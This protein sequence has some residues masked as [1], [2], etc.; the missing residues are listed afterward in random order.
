MRAARRQ[1]AAAPDPGADHELSG[2]ITAALAED[3]TEPADELAAAELP[4]PGGAATGAGAHDAENVSPELAEAIAGWRAGL[5]ELAGGSS[6]ADIGLLG[7][8]VI[9]LSAAHPSGVAQLFAGRPTRLSNLVREV[10]ALPAARRRAQAVAARSAEHAQRYGVA[11]TYLA[12]GV[13]T[14]TERSAP[15]RT[16][17]DMEALARVTGR[18][19]NPWEHVA[20]AEPDE[21]SPAAPTPDTPSGTDAPAPRAVRAPVL[22]RPVTLTPRGDSEADYDIT[23]EAS[24]EINPVVARTLR[25]HGA[26]LDPAALAKAAFT[27][28]GFDPT[29]VLH[30]VASLGAAVLGDFE[31]DQRVLVGTFVHPGQVL[32]DDLDE[33]TPSLGRHEVV[34]AAGGVDEAIGTLRAL[35][36]PEPRVGDA[37]PARERGVGDLD[38]RQRHV[39]DALATGNHLFVDA[40][41]GS[42][43]AGTL[44]AVVAEANAS[45]RSVLYVPGHRRAADALIAR[46]ESL[47]LDGLLLDVAPTPSWRQIVS[48]RLLSAMTAGTGAVDTDAIARVRD[49]LIGARSQLAGYI[50]AL[51]EPRGPQRISAYDALQALA[52]LTSQKPA[53]STTVRLPPDTVLGLTEDKRAEHARDLARAAELGAF[54]LKSSTSPWFGAQ[55]T[56]DRA[57][58]DAL[59]R[60]RRLHDET[61]PR[62]R[63]QIDYVV[64]VTGLV[65]ATCLAQWAEQLAMLA[66]MRGTLDVFQPMVFER[67]VED[68]VHATASGRW[69]AEH[70]IELGW[71]ER[72]RLRKRARGMV[73]PGVRL[74]DMHEALLEVAEQREIWQEQCPRGGWPTLPEGLASI[75]ETYEAVRI[76]V[77]ALEPALATSYAGGGLAGLDLDALLQRLDALAGDADALTTLP[78][79]TAI[80]LHARGAGLGDLVDDLAV[81]R[82]EP[83]QVGAEL[84]LAWW[85]SVFEE[86]LASEPALAEQDGAGLDALAGRFRELDLRHVDALPGPVRVAVRAHLGSAMREERDDAEALYTELVEGKLTSVRDMV[87]N[88]G[89]VARRLRP[90]MISTP[91]LV[92]HLLPPERCADLVVLDAVQHVPLEVVV[93]AIARGR[94]VMVVGDPRSA[95]GTAV[96][97]LS[98]LLPAVS[99][100]SEPSRRDPALTTLLA[101]HG[102]DGVLRPAPVPRTEAL[103]RHWLVDGTGMPDPVSGAVES[104]RAEVD[105]VVELAI[106]HAMTRPEETFGIVTVT[107]AH[108]DRIREALL[109]EV[110]SNPALAPFFSG[111]RPEPVVVADV[112]GVAGLQRDTIVLTLGFGRTPHGRVLHRFGALG[113]AGGDGMLLGALGATRKRLHVVSCFGADDIDPERLRGPGPK[114][115]RE[116]LAFAASRD[117][118]ADDVEL[119]NG[120]DVARE[121]DRLVG[122]LGERLWKAG[123]VVETDYGIGDG[124]RIPLAVGHPDLPG[125]LLVAVLTDDAA[126]VA[127]PSIRVRDRQLANRLEK[128]GWVVAQVWSAAAFLDPDAEAE[129]VRRVVLRVRDA[130]VGAGGVVTVPHVVE[131]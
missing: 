72:R 113:E 121:P 96:R 107:A 118:Q 4:P 74:S 54:S 37:N 101:E 55:I 18:A 108:A 47:G 46:L 53:P 65:P 21:A 8:A 29:D 44:A 70:G 91:T 111:K 20:D 34:A 33:L 106:D 97:E 82:V 19:E 45:G 119:G 116:V 92:P 36:L 56:T 42:D 16:D 64:Q 80:L 71:L 43:V 39:V 30:R 2:Q 15:G 129:R 35:D 40:P 89:A 100:T 73:R 110:R 99:L 7:E 24:A 31:L 48:H 109:A 28:A 52:R 130:R 105:R 93:P 11:P 3:V 84:D 98:D 122:D 102:Y 127:E 17:D 41:V 32:V 38:P 23:L 26:L 120:V 14:W 94:Q 90:T 61:L 104:T 86:I 68:L 78:E 51:H 85:S 9:D 126:Y 62:L 50:D 115:L 66:G 22:L 95:S 81:R 117:G 59:T 6:L 69:R 131:G 27:I 125:E 128:L 103:V 63:E 57:A 77:E 75:E 67:T 49:A 10:G 1:T 123:L 114:L 83:A 76:D 58:R 87:A 25:A 79:R 88:H 112:S 124:E 5:V 60:V 13:A 12:I